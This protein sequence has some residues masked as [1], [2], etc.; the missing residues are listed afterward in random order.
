MALRELIIVKIS[1]LTGRAVY[2]R[3]F[4]SDGNTSE[5]IDLKDNG[6]GV[7]LIEVSDRTNVWVKKMVVK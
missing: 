5:S 7:Y 3:S 1:D 2:Q 6:R 4:N